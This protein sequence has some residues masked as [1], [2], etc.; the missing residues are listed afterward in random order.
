MEWL[1][2]LT[3][4]EE[5]RYDVVGAPRPHLDPSCSP[6]RRPVLCL[7]PFSARWPPDRS[8]HP[9]PLPTLSFSSSNWEWG[10]SQ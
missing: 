8:P 7:R 6:L 10:A 1:L 2:R 5:P 4:A 9:L 3:P